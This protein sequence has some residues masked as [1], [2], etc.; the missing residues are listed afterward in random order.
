[1][2]VSTASGGSFPMIGTIY[3]SL[4]RIDIT[5]ERADIIL[6]RADI[7]LERLMLP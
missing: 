7:T 6:E 5:L 2:Y 4:E 3:F 1:M